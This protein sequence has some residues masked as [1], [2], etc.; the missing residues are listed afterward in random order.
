M[1]NFY[2]KNCGTKKSSVSQLAGSG[3]PKGGRH[4]L[5]EGSEKDEYTCKYCGIEKNTIALLIGSGCSK[6]PN[7]KRH[8]PA[9]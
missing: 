6:N 7:G 9:L 4:E 2:C 8:S 5:Y 3:C 1:A